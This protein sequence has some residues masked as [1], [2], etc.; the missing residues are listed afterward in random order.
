MNIAWLLVVFVIA[1][2]LF[3]PTAGF[4]RRRSR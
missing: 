3:G 1:L 4:G 2:I